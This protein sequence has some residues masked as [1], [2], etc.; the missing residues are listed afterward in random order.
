MLN[1]PIIFMTNDLYYS[2]LS[3]EFGLQLFPLS[4]RQLISNIHPNQVHIRK[5]LWRQS[6]SS[7]SIMK[8]ANGKTNKIHPPTQMELLVPSLAQELQAR[9]VL[10][11]HQRPKVFIDSRYLHFQII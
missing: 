1:T 3:T 11:R 7:C 8:V 2:R 4:Y 5:K 9:Q 6:G 10:R